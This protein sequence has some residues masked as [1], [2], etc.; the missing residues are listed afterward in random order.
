MSDSQVYESSTLGRD[1]LLKI[2]RDLQE[3]KNGPKGTTTRKLL[4]WFGQERR[5]VHVRRQIREAL[6]EAKLK[7]LPDF[8]AAYIDGKITFE[9]LTEP[10]TIK[11]IQET[12]IDNS[13][14]VT[15]DPTFR[16]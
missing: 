15:S 7:T 8:E 9:L 5:G 1:N 13:S 6:A 4:E 11:P 14:Q 2:A 16:I 10:K 12:E 3:K